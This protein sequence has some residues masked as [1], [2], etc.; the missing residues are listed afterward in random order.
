MRKLGG[1]L[2]A[3]ALQLKYLVSIPAPDT[4]LWNETCASRQTRKQTD[5][6]TINNFN[7]L[8]TNTNKTKS[9]SNLGTITEQ[10][11]VI[12]RVD[13][14]VL[15]LVRGAHQA[16]GI[17][18]TIGKRGR[19][20]KFRKRNVPKFGC[21]NSRPFSIAPRTAYNAGQTVVHHT[22]SGFVAVVVV[23][24]LL[25]HIVGAAARFS[26][27]FCCPIRLKHDRCQTK[28]NHTSHRKQDKYL[29]LY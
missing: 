27:G 7:K 15:S 23:L 25:P 12:E 8:K 21:V 20:V 6:G 3:F 14:A 16:C 24:T 4:T 2:L 19:N 22:K 1:L 11:R 13:A 26:L 17:R 5:S 29:L 9:K 18:Y 28:Q 10:A